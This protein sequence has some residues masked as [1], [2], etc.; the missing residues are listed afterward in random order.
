M[1]EAKDSVSDI[2]LDKAELM[3]RYVSDVVL[4]LNQLKKTNYSS[5]DGSIRSYDIRQGMLKTDA[6]D[7]KHA[8]HFL[9]VRYID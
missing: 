4:F 1:T 2:I 5:I 8:I 6:M 7:G 9:V 3:T